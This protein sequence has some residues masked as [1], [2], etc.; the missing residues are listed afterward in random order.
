MST[1]SRSPGV[2]SLALSAPQAPGPEAGASGRDGRPLV[3][4]QSVTKEFGH[5]VALRGANL[6]VMPGEIVGLIGDNGAGK[7]TL[8]KVLA[9]VLAP[10]SGRVLFD[11]RSVHFRSPSE[12]REA[13]IETVYQDLA[14]AE[15]LDCSANLFLGRESTLTGWRRRLGVLAKRE[16]RE[17]TERLLDEFGIHIEDVNAPV[18]TL[19]GGQRQSLSVVRSVGWPC[20]LVLLD[21]PTA[22]LGVEQTGQVLALARRIRDAGVSV[23]YISHNMPQVVEVT[24]RIEVL[25]LG[26][27]VARFQSSDVST[28]DLVAAMTG[29]LVTEEEVA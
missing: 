20:K 9:G 16:M 28:A 13:G 14:L 18:S 27:R 29:A 1:S 21:E 26:R 11:G 7:T 10:D 2:E 17:R 22:A 5:V 23:V 3:E 15:D 25:R 6:T 12:A 24:D 4:V 8:I 19:S